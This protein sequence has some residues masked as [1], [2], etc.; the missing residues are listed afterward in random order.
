MKHFD[1]TVVGKLNLDLIPSGLPEALSAERELLASSQEV[2]LGSSS[3]IFAHNLSKLGS[4][5]G[6]FTRIG[7]NPLWQI[8]LERLAEAGVGVS[9]VK[10]GAG[11]I[12]SGLSVILAHERSRHILT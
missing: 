7:L 5:V 11:P 6:V 9:K 10:K 8:V 12:Q 1:V 3:T 4:Q 2:T